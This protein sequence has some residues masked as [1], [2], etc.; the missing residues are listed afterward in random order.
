MR[1]EQTFN[2]RNPEEKDWLL[3]NNWYP[4]CNKAYTE[5]NNPIEYEED[6]KISL[7][8]ICKI[9]GCSCISEIKIKST[10]NKV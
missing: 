3:N 6:G 4:N 2:S 10:S 7:S 5:I 1:T 9:C 8:C